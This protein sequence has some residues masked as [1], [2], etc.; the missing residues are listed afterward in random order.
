MSLNLIKMLFAEGLGRH[1][2]AFLK[3][4]TKIALRI[5][6]ATFGNVDYRHIAG[7]QQALS[8][9]KP[10]SGDKFVGRK[11]GHLREYAVKIG[12]AQMTPFGQNFGAQGFGIMLTDIFHRGLD[13]R[14]ACVGRCVVRGADGTVLS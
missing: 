1:F 9:R 6:A 7:G 13:C 8:R 14:L 5:K 11:V 4:I 12:R 3:N 2:E 10:C